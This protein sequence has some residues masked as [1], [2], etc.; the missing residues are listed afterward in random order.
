MIIVFEER[1]RYI[2]IGKGIVFREG[3]KGFC[4]DKNITGLIWN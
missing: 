1:V 4:N 2:N 3:L